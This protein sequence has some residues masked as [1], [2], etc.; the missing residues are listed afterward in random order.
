LGALG[1]E[2]EGQH[3][4]DRDNVGEEQDEP[5]FFFSVRLAVV[6]LLVDFSLGMMAEEGSDC[7][8]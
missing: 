2:R 7:F 5:F 4:C 1:S 3:D 8:D 6:A